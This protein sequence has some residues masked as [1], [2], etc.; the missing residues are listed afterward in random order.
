VTVES[1]LSGPERADGPG[2]ARP[3]VG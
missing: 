2:T 3:G 1:S